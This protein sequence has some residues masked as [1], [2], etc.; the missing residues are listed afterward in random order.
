MFFND[1]PPQYTGQ[2]ASDLIKDILMSEK[3]CMISRFGSTELNCIHTYK[4]KNKN[5]IV[6]QVKYI[7]G[8]IDSFEWSGDIKHSMSNNAGF[9]PTL[10]KKLEDF[11][12]LMIK[13]MKNVDILGSW[14]FQENYFNKELKNVKKV[15]LEDLVPF[16]HKN[17][18]SYALKG[19]VILVVHPFD[20]SINSQYQRKDL[21]FK[22]KQV[23]PDFKLIT[24][25]PVQSFLGNH[26][27]LEYKDW[28]EALEKM[29]ED[30][31]RLEFDIAI[32]G[33]GAYGFPLASFIKRIGKKSIHMG[34][35]TQLLFG[36]LGKRWEQEYDLSN[37]INEYWIRPNL[38]E[39]P[40]NFQ[41]VENGCYW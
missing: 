29:K 26:E 22:N 21:L 15:H 31:S 8:N 11:S 32:I 37:F 18:W 39:K 13:E 30:I 3:P 17:P 41:N 38:N 12:K 35:A 25:R 24:Y 4:N 5:L 27:N 33:C 1:R 10:D 7:K 9:F 2:V 36:V 40:K 34:G 6:R 16:N 20:E 23:L 14:L 28:F 19:K